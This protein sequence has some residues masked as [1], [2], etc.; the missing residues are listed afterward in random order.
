MRRE[1]A[2]LIHKQPLLTQA[3]HI[4][5]DLGGSQLITPGLIGAV[6]GI[7]DH[8]SQSQPVSISM[9]YSPMFLTDSNHTH[10]KCNNP[11]QRKVRSRRHQKPPPGARLL[12]DRILCAYHYR[13]GRLVTN[14][15]MQRFFHSGIGREAE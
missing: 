1:G 10:E 3:C 8:D 15:L 6:G 4:L 7:K 13:L 2:G 11:I 14:A 12:N 9:R 5:D